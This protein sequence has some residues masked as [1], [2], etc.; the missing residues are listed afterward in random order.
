MEQYII[1]STEIDS[2]ENQLYPILVGISP[3]AKYPS[4]GRLRASTAC[5]PYI[6]AYRREDEEGKGGGTGKG[7]GA[8]LDGNDWR[9][10]GDQRMP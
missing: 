10:D 3:L 4:V 2:L 9:G 8:D 1:R 6:L 5:V 7:R